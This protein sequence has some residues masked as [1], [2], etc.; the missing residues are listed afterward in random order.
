MIQLKFAKVDQTGWTDFDQSN[1]GFSVNLLDQNHSNGFRLALDI[2]DK[3]VDEKEMLDEKKR[4]VEN[5][6][7]SAFVDSFFLLM[8]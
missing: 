2:C 5:I 8:E 1:M 7:K 6:T 3:H 4:T